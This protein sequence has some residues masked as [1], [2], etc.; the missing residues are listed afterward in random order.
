MNTYSST[1]YMVGA[2]YARDLVRGLDEMLAML[3]N[4]DTDGATR[5]A[6]GMQE[7]AHVMVDTLEIIRSSETDTD[8]FDEPVPEE[9]EPWKA[10][11]S[12]LEDD[13]R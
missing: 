7:G 3:R 5:L 13:G 10:S 12:P 2:L 9:A 1:F 6:A 11:V 4:G 8:K